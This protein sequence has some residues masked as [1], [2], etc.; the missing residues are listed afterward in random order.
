MANAREIHAV[1][2]NFG[3]WADN[4]DT[5]LRFT[6]RDAATWLHA[7]TTNH[8]ASLKTGHGTQ[9][10]LLDRTGRVLAVF[11]VYRWEDEYWVIVPSASKPEI[12]ARI[13]S[14]LFLEDV[15]ME[16]VGGG[17]KH[18]RLEG[19]RTLIFLDAIMAGGKLTS[20][21]SLPAGL[22]TVAPVKILNHEVLAFRESISGEDGFRLI[23]AP[24]ED[25]ALL[26][27]L[28]DHARE[29]MAAQVSPEAAHVLRV[30][31]GAPAFGID[32]S[33]AHVI[34]ETPYEHTAVAYDKGCYL[35]QEVVAR[36]KAYGTP[37]TALVGLLGD[38]A[39]T[40]PPPPGTALHVDGAR[41]G[42]MCSSAYSPTLEAWIALAYL[43]RNH[44]TPGTHLQ[45]AT[46]DAPGDTFNAHVRALPLVQTRPR[47]DYARALYDEALQHFEQD[48]KDEDDTAITALKEA[49]LLAPD[50][51]DAYEALGV[52]LH[53]HHRVDEAIH[54]MKLLARLNPNCV[55]AHTNLSVFYVSK[56]M[57]TEAE[58][59]KALANQLEF[60]RQIDAR[61]AEKIAEA[62][63]ARIRREAEEKIAMFK[64]V[65]EIDPEDP[66][67]TMGLG[68]SYMQLDQYADAIPHLE[69][70][71]RVKKDYSAAFLNLGKCHEFLGHTAE[72][73]NAYQAGI[74]AAS[75]K[76]DLMPLREMERRLKALEKSLGKC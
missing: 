2:E 18:L 66:I 13:E 71:V 60:K 26:E 35:G 70:A 46:A 65:L 75:R 3:L 34:N 44:R 74:E 29:F 11:H 20:A 63:R 12:E 59:E 15:Q 22:N 21:R 27:A 68:A 64:E 24:G 52:I 6:G 73:T 36:L 23:P 67:A 51:E 19:P 32:A 56:G 31:A 50:F 14:H 9:N 10:A 17:A 42:E 61:D 69:T 49:I 72:A 8:I 30:E 40:A 48:A 25:D 76:G 37:K 39:A 33:P 16:D 55:M 58:T 5:V 54:Y 4:A 43:D 28:T 1:R 45:L 62:E 47:A 38:P 53:R 57:I 41:V 7:Q